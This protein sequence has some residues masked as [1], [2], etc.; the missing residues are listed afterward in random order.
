MELGLQ[1]GEGRVGGTF[2]T[3]TKKLA[4]GTVRL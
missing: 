3:V 4:M 2:N 1:L